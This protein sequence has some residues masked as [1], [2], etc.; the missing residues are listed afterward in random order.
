MPPACNGLTC[1]TVWMSRE[2]R[3]LG[4]TLFV[5]LARIPF[6]IPDAELARMAQEILE[7]SPVFLDTDP[8]HAVRFALFCERNN[9]KFPSLKFIL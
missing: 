7:W 2:Q 6:L 5:N 1:P 4:Q 3:I 8:V 9:I